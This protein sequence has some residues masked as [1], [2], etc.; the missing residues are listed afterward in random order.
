MPALEAVHELKGRRF[1]L[2]VETSDSGEDYL[3]Y[4]REEEMM[5]VMDRTTT[6][7]APVT[8]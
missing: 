7:P 3:K 2:T 4:E 5:V 1:L 8:W 6:S